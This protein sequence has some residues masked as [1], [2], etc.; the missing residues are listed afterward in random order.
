M[1]GWDERPSRPQGSDRFP[2]PAQDVESFEAAQ[3][4]IDPGFGTGIDDYGVEVLARLGES[5]GALFFSIG[6]AY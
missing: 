5:R 3:D 6:Q 2:P 4:A 1:M